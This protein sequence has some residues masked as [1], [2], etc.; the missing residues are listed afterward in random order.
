M[1]HNPYPDLHPQPTSGCDTPLPYNKEAVCHN[2]A[3]QNLRGSAK[4]PVTPWLLREPPLTASLTL[5]RAHADSIIAPRDCLAAP[6][7]RPS[8]YPLLLRLRAASVCLRAFS[9]WLRDTCTRDIL[10]GA[11]QSTPIAP[12]GSTPA[13]IARVDH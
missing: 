12:L 3:F 11:P 13:P 5:P 10:L 1:T 4:C 2:E 9:V 7:L 6:P 8:V